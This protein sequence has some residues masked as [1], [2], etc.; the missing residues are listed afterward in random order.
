MNTKEIDQEKISAFADGELADSQVETVLASMRHR[1]R[2]ED[3]DI[4]HQM[5]DVLRSDDLSVTL[6]SG[7]AARMEAR[8]EMEPTIIA[9]AA[10]DILAKASVAGLEQRTAAAPVISDSR[11]TKRWATRGLAAAAVAAVAFVM[12][13]PLL[14]AM[15]G[16]PALSGAPV[17]VARDVTAPAA[18]QVSSRSPVVAAG[19]AEGVILRDP[20]IDD[21][22]LAH[23]QFSPSVY[24]TAQ[25]ARSTTLATNS[26]K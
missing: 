5:G 11:F 18:V 22:L 14:D 7:F 21:Y 16:D 2:Q 20:R 15:K 13:P 10:A 17:T 26:S 3:W 8:L 9:P 6:S 25:Y 23:Q 1:E 24:S 19:V 4:Y 12:T